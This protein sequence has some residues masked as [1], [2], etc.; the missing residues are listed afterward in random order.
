MTSKATMYTIVFAGATHNAFRH[1]GMEAS[2][3][4]QLLRI[5]YKTQAIAELR[6]ALNDLRGP[7][8]E[9]L[10]MCI[11]TLAAH[12]SGEE[13]SPPSVEE[14][15]AASPLSKAQDFHYYAAMRWEEAHLEAIQKLIIARGGLLSIRTPGL[16]GA[17]VL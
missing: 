3:N 6:K 2:N 11:I 4:N 15:E 1:V 16:L 13:L 9:E 17:I 12:G 10:L 5:S 8:S 14:Y 7:V